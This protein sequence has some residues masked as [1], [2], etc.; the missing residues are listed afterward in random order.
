MEASRGE[1]RLDFTGLALRLRESGKVVYGP[2]GSRTPQSLQNACDRFI[3]LEV[4]ARSPPAEAAEDTTGRA[5]GSPAD[6]LADEAPQLNLESALTRAVSARDD[7]GWTASAATATKQPS[8]RNWPRQAVVTGVGAGLPDQGRRSCGQGSTT[9]RSRVGGEARRPLAKRQRDSRLAPAQQAPKA[10]A[11]AKQAAA[12]PRKVD[13]PA[14]PVHRPSSSGSA[15]SASPAETGEDEAAARSRTSAPGGAINS[16]SHDDGRTTLRR[17]GATSRPTTRRR[18]P[19]LPRPQAH[20]AGAGP[21]RA[22][23]A[24][25]AKPVVRPGRPARRGRPRRPRRRREEPRQADHPA[26]PPGRP[27]KQPTSAGR[28]AR[29]PSAA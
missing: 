26:G 14:K 17:R 27:S 19:Q 4:P 13:A 20:R 6:G 10:D 15:A 3:A 12:D 22:G 28:T 9:R 5:A 11:P 21:G 1:Q 25:P 29:T 2:G 7:E 23:R 16:T 18:L 24:G 8:P